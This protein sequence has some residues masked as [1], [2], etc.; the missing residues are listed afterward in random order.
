MNQ[1]VTKNI[2]LR[3]KLD[4]IARDFMLILDVVVTD[5]GIVQR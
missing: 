1:N 3:G 5:K 2:I 4:L